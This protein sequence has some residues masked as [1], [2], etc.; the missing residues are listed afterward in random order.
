M[1]FAKYW[2]ANFI[3]MDMY[4]SI[5]ISVFFFIWSFFVNKEQFLN[6]Y[7]HDNREVFYGALTTL[8]GTLL[9][10]IIT[11]ISIV[12]GYSANE[13]LAIVK[14]S[15]HYQDLWDIFKTAIRVLATITIFSLLGL[16]FDNNQKPFNAF[17]YITF[18]L[19]VLSVFRVGRCIW[20][21]EKIMLI[22]T[23]KQ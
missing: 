20:V 9:G 15:K 18:F 14:E 4:L 3:K 17:L 8:F 6:T 21:L 1:K 10:F 7:F 12:L 5:V 22:V 11:A 2:A 19:V 13:K 23:K 16:V